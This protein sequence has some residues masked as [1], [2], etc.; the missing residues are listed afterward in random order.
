MTTPTSGYRMTT[1]EIVDTARNAKLW[2]CG[3]VVLQSGEDP[4]FTADILCD[5]VRRVKAE[6]PAW[7]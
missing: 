3:T 6:S 4:F 5:V 1:E 2:G 7:R